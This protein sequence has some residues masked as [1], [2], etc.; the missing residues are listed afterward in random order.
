MIMHSDSHTSRC[1]FN[2]YIYHFFINS[3]TPWTL[4]NKYTNSQ[5]TIQRRMHNNI[6]QLQNQQGERMEEHDDIERELIT[7]FKYV[8]QEPQVN[9]QSAINK[10]LQHVPKIITE[11]H[12][13]L[14]LRLVTLLEVESTLDQMKDGKAPGP[15][16]FTSN[17][18]HH[19]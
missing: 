16:G 10:I 2:T 1:E 4:G 15:D 5:S 7:H 14:L 18:F 12:N 8:H 19:F 17:F 3:T 13:Q 6:L 11:E 9:R